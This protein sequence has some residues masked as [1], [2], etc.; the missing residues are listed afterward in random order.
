M[1]AE[2]INS[3]IELLGAQMEAW[4]GALS[5]LYAAVSPGVNE[6]ELYGFDTDGGLRGY[7]AF[8]PLIPI[9]MDEA[10]AK[11]L[12]EAAEAYTGIVFP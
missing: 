12:W 7:P 2:A 1:T 10:A 9:A 6:A 3:F 5:T 8:N 4:Q 11:R